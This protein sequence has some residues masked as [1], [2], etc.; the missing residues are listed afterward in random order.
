VVSACYSGG[1]VEALKSETTLVMTAADAYHTSFGCGS[2]SDFTYFGKAYFDQALRKHSSF[3]A[4]F[5]EA[6]HIIE[7]RERS[8]G[9]TPSNPQMFIGAAM[10]EKLQAFEAHLVK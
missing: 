5:H 1:F 7:T 3:T 6:R 2:E 8:E 10:Q 4:A 9:K